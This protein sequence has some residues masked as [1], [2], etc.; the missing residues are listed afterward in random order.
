MKK[1][2]T[3]SL[4]SE[5]DFEH[6]NK[7]ILAFDHTEISCLSSKITQ[8]PNCNYEIVDARGAPRFKGEVAE[9]RPGLRSGNIPGSKNVPFNKVLNE[10]FT[11][12]SKEDIIQQFKQSN[13]DTSKEIVGT[14][15]SGVT[16]SVL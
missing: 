1:I 2:Q 14:C 16:A 3:S 4:G 15:G 12:K 7:E 9:P 13:I 10:D 5:F 6:S 11:Y 8:S